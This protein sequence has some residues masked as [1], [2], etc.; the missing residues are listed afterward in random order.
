M[1]STFLGL[2]PSG[3]VLICTILSFVVPLGTY[4]INQ[5]LHKNGDPPWKQQNE[6]AQQ[7]SKPPE[8]KT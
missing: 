6:T 4:L 3:L 8:A 5:L 7:Q 2:M 1:W